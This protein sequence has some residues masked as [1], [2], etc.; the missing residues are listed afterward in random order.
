MRRIIPAASEMESDMTIHR[1]HDVH[2]IFACA[3]SAILEAVRPV[4]GR[5]FVH[6]S[7][8]HHVIRAIGILGR[9]VR[10]AVLFGAAGVSS[11]W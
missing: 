6:P 1:A 10:G 11:S 9:E 8:R 5:A 4:V 2:L 3:G 7:V